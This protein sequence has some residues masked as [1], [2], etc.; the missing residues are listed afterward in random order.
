VIDADG[1][2]DAIGSIGR[3]S[4]HVTNLKREIQY[5]A[6][7]D[8]LICKADMESSSRLQPSLY[9]LLGEKASKEAKEQMH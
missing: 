3:S 8:V 6:F 2:T 7:K 1:E 4:D 9:L 5:E